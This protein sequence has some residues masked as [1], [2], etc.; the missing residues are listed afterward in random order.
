MKAKIGVREVETMGEVG[1]ML[2][3][4]LLL[5]ILWQRGSADF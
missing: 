5:P 4:P 2:V 1:E 3:L